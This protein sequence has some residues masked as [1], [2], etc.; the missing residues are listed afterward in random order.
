MHRQSERI[1]GDEERT[2]PLRQSYT[3]V[4]GRMRTDAA[5][6]G[7]LLNEKGDSKDAPSNRVKRAKA[8]EQDESDMADLAPR[9]TRWL[10]EQDEGTSSE[11]DD[12]SINVFDVMQAGVAGR[13][14]EKEML[15]KIKS[16]RELSERNNPSFVVAL[17]SLDIDKDST[18]LLNLVDAYR[19][20]LSKEGDTEEH[21]AARNR[22]NVLIRQS[23]S[24]ADLRLLESRRDSLPLDR[25]GQ[26][27]VERVAASGKNDTAVSFRLRVYQKPMPENTREVIL[28]KIGEMT[29]F[30]EGGSGEEALK[31]QV[32]IEWALLVPFSE[33][34]RSPEPDEVS[35]TLSRLARELD[36]LVYGME[37]VKGHVLLAVN[38]RLRNPRQKGASIALVGPPGVG[39]TSIVK[40]VARALDLPLRQIS[41]GSVTTEDFLVGHQSIFIGAGPGEIVRLLCD[42]K[43][44][45]PILLCDEYD[46]TSN[47]PVVASAMLHITDP[48]QQ[49]T[50]F[51]DKYLNGVAVD[52]SQVWFF[53]SM[54]TI[55]ANA[56][57][58][59]RFMIVEVPGYKRTEKTIML[60]RHIVPSILQHA[61]LSPED[62]IF[63][64]DS[65]NRLVD[66]TS[67]ADS[68]GVRQLRFLAETVV[69]KVMYMVQNA[70]EV[71]DVG[72]DYAVGKNLP[73]ER[74]FPF[75]VNLAFLN[76][77]SS[78]PKSSAA[79]MAHPSM[80][81]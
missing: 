1:A 14:D 33:M 53:Y 70:F 52:I 29:R 61:G 21:I 34:A 68:S 67:D 66:M 9:I 74:R 2:K 13:A 81:L 55:P 18:H 12:D 25:E 51:R 50:E 73:G 62:I 15:K 39:K 42:A 46:A 71:E 78:L 43:V 17:K 56:A 72:L 44:K 36:S 45:N 65:C 41:F 37:N 60:R 47:H 11:E 57:F 49:E 20:Y 38:A 8:S 10:R 6:Q 80:Y 48:V 7:A 76:S 31:C 16:L 23:Q 58:R 35:K 69:H 59:D 79:G 19:V 3:P 24:H 30:L 28:G 75:V 77:V 4:V 64:D 54:N 22:L 5:L 63:D 27:A 32:W 26:Q 40:V